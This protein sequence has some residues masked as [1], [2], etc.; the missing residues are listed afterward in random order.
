MAFGL[1]QCLPGLAVLLSVTL[2]DASRVVDQKEGSFEP[3]LCEAGESCGESCKTVYF[4]RHAEGKHQVANEEHK[5]SDAGQQAI[6]A[7]KGIP[8]KKSELRTW[9][10]WPVAHQNPA[11]QEL[12]DSELTEK[13]KQQCQAKRHIPL[14]VELV[15]VSPL[16]RTLETAFLLFRGRHDKFLV[17]DL[18]RER[19]GEF[20]CDQRRS[21]SE[22]RAWKPADL[23][24]V[25]TW[26]DWDWSTQQFAPTADERQ[27]D[28]PYSDEDSLWSPE[29]EPE[30]HT[31][32]RSKVLLR[33]LHER[34]EQSLALV[35]HSSFMRNMFGTSTVPSNAE[36]MEKQLCMTPVGQ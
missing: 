26:Q 11:S 22:N 9:E 21:L 19:Y 5:K 16:R 28:V 10:N 7:L 29:R 33:F 20:T 13:G 24:D 12:V 25:K 2:C 35:T 23:A 34:T 31:V 27:P 1:A 3:V 14:P 18:A 36:P 6:A 15:V 17:H 8:E 4:I 32:A 30:P